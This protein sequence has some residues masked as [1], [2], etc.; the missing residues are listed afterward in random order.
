MT[1]KIA[2]IDELKKQFAWQD[3]LN[4]KQ[5]ISRLGNLFVVYI[6]QKMGLSFDFTFG[7]E[8]LGKPFF[9]YNNKLHF[10][11]SDSKQYIAIVLNDKRVGIDIEYLREN[12]K[13]IA[14]R[15]FHPKE[16]EY[17]DKYVGN[18]YDQAFTQLWTIK[19]AYVKM[20][21]AGIGGYFKTIDLSPKEFIIEQDYTKNSHHIHSY[22][23][24]E[25][26]LF[27]TIVEE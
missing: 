15:N 18:E 24:N 14:K 22:Y 3:N 19:E 9:L 21:G 12:K 4:T 20:T 7:F 25:L 16:V 1:I 5:N 11:I 10:S 17:L 23:N 2:T 13:E 27:I 26:Q 8:S 6:V